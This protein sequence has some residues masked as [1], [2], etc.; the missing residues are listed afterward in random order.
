MLCT[1]NRKKETCSVHFA[2]RGKALLWSFFHLN[3]SVS[4]LYTYNTE[5]VALA[6][7]TMNLIEWEFLLCEWSLFGLSALLFQLG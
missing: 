7:G 5:F 4:G 1:F 2:A 3:C 6:L